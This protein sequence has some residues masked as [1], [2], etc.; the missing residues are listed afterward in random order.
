[1]LFKKSTDVF[2]LIFSQVKYSYMTHALDISVH[3]CAGDPKC[4]KL[5]FFDSFFY[6]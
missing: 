4:S 2:L 6:S 5:L 1:M 3:T